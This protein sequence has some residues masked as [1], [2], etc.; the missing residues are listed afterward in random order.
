MVGLGELLASAEQSD[1]SLAVTVPE[2]WLQGRTAYGGLSA[3]VGYRAARAAGGDLPPLRS[4]QIAFVGPVSGRVQARATVLRRGRSSAFV[5]ARIADDEAVLMVAI[6]LFMGERN[7]S[8]HVEPPPHDAPPPETAQPAMRRRPGAPAFRANLE[9]RHAAAESERAKPEL[10]RWVR[11]R[12]RAGLDPATELLAIGDALPPGAVPLLAA[13]APVSSANWSLNFLDS[14]PQTRDGW[15][16]LRSRADFA[17]RGNSSQTMSV[18][19][20]DGQAM[21]MGMQQIAL[22][23]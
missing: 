10:M 3:A 1:G 2:E 9:Y 16:L 12:D 5:E 14:Q 22:F 15:W 17:A 11:L 6:F 20:R 23:G 13:P 19:N 8:L 18:W 7:S 21:M 4:A